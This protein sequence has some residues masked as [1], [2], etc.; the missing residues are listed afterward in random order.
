MNTETKPQHT[1]TPW[2]LHP[3]NSRSIYGPYK[4]NDQL[5]ASVY[6][7]EDETDKYPEAIANAAFIVRCTNNHQKLI[8]ALKNV[9]GLFKEDSSTVE[10]IDEVLNEAQK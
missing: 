9:R 3:G 8:D 2:R 7:G 6:M 1:P 10:M 4:G 5:I